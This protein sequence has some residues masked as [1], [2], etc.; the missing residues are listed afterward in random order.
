MESGESNEVPKPKRA[1]KLSLKKRKKERKL[2]NGNEEGKKER[3]RRRT[4][5]L[6]I[7]S[8]SPLDDQCCP[9]EFQDE[10]F[11]RNNLSDKKR[12]EKSHLKKNNKMQHLTKANNKSVD[13]ERI[14]H[15]KDAN[16][17]NNV[18]QLK[19]RGAGL[20][21]T[22][23]PTPIKSEELKTSDYTGASTNEGNQ[24]TDPI[25]IQSAKENESTN[26]AYDDSTVTSLDQAT[27]I[28]DREHHKNLKKNDVVARQGPRQPLSPVKNKVDVKEEKIQVCKE[29]DEI[30]ILEGN[31]I[32]AK[33]D[34]PIQLQEAN[35]KKDLS[36]SNSKQQSLSAFIKPKVDPKSD[37]MCYDLN[38]PS[39]KDF[40]VSN[41]KFLA[42]NE[43]MRKQ[44]HDKLL[45]E[46][47]NNLKPKKNSKSKLKFKKCGL[48]TTCSC[49][50]GGSLQALED[51]AVNDNQNPLQML[52]D[53]EAGKERAL[54]NR[55]ARL[56]KS[57][58]W[59]DSLCTKVS[60]ELT[61]H[62]NKIKAKM[63]TVD[64]KNAPKFLRDVDM[65]E[66]TNFSASP[67]SES[68]VCNAVQKTFVFRKSKYLKL[69][70]IYHL[71]IMLTILHKTKS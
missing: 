46:S 4:R 12:T 38:S 69:L 29:I 43:T 6:P 63:Q 7:P 44:M 62:R 24:Y 57:A 37:T 25:I 30:E 16:R 14:K 13:E 64:L 45:Q 8:F 33:K 52:A 11:N 58:S 20:S 17:S 50:R 42:D 53:T 55:L 2:D 5:D 61:R 9:F 21:L 54:I 32:P 27:T 65:D 18:E 19:S 49:N 40:N 71:K 31:Q 41:A 3:K 22:K 51:S 34:T 26:E 47:K 59:F 36:R 35:T 68:H 10:D 1:S 28:E 60:R 70:S 67:F 66:D 15:T 39:M 23:K 48:C 56:E